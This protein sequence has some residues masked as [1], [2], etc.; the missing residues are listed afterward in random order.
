M[1]EPR[2]NLLFVCIETLVTDLIADATH[3]ETTQ[4]ERHG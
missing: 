3:P 1:P 4:E 2:P